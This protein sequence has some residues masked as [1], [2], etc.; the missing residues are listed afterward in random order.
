MSVT[1]TS[2]VNIKWYEETLFTLAKLE[3]GQTELRKEILCKGD[4]KST[5]ISAHSIESVAVTV[6]FNLRKLSAEEKFHI[7]VK[8][9]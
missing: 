4:V 2:K 5:C 8:V 3:K 9:K 6:N 7:K 1:I